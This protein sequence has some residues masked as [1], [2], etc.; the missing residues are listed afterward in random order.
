MVQ[1]LRDKAKNIFTM[2][3]LISYNCRGLH[4]GKCKAKRFVVDNL[5]MDAD[6]LCLQE[7][8]L[9]RQDLKV[10]NGITKS[11]HGIGEASRDKQDG[12]IMGHPPGGVAIFWNIKYEEYISELK[13]DLDWVVGIQVEF[14]NRKFVILNVYMPHQSPENEEEYLCKLGQLTSIIDELETTSISLIGDFNANILSSTSLFVNHLNLF[15]DDNNLILSSKKYLPND[16]FTYVSESWHTVSWLDHCISTNDMHKAVVKMEILYSLASTDH[17]PFAVNLDINCV[18]STLCEKSI[19]KSRIDWSSLKDEDINLYCNYTDLLLNNINICNE[20]LACSNASCSDHNHKRSLINMYDQIVDCLAKASQGLGKNSGSTHYNKPGWNDHVS[21]LYKLSRDAFLVWK[22]SGKPRHGDVFEMKRRANARFKYALRYISNHEEVLRRESLARKLLNKNPKE[23]WKEIK[24]MNNCN[25]SLPTNIEGV[26]GKKN[27]AELWRKHY[28]ELFNSINK[29]NDMSPT[30][31]YSNDMVVYGTEIEYAIGKLDLNKTSGLDG[32]TAEHLKYCSKRINTLLAHCFT[33]LIIHGILPDSMLSIVLVPVIKDKTGQIND[34][35][36]YRPIALASVLSK[37][38]E[39]IILSRLEEFLYTNHNQ[40]GFKKKL[41]TDICIYTLKEILSK[42]ASL[43]ANM[44]LCFLD[45]SKA[46][47]RVNHDKLF[48]KL[49]DRKVPGYLVRILI[50]WYNHQKMTVRWGDETSNS[51]TVS[52]GVRQGGILSPWLFNVY[53]DGL[54]DKL[55]TC[56]VG[57]VIGSVIV[58]H[59]MYADDLVIFSPSA[60]GLTALINI[61][62]AYGDE[63]DILYNQKKSA[64]MIVRTSQYKNVKFP[65]FHLNGVKL[66]EL[67][68]IKYLGHMLS[69]DLSDDM[70]IIRQNRQLYSQGNSLIRKFHMCTKEI[71]IMLF[72]T[73]CS[74]MYTVQLWWNYK[75]GTIRKLYVAYNNIFRLL[76]GIPRFNN[77]VN[78]SAS[79]TFVSNEVSNCASLIRKLVYR[80]ITR[81]DSCNNALTAMLVGGVDCDTFFTSKIRKHWRSLLYLS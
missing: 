67:N 57:C 72:K 42:Y 33:G 44:F 63:N 27:I 79:H 9:W 70:D 69:S 2:M 58:N 18:P 16:S 78:Y 76:L 32:V 6:I 41:G 59:L 74:S 19:H 45:A 75:L 22:D 77:N 23:F 53:M 47:D 62:T 20:T 5:F 29:N 49:L 10:L 11:F 4:V 36:N 61:C 56:K 80:F 52:N 35:C 51:F 34:T 40:F 38:F 37:V 24:I 30:V 12:L 39:Y 64:V 73:Y 43:N 60:K 25:M 21:D 15:C 28:F 65:P 55:N 50:F 17:I 31:T 7:T 48:S 8:W 1:I 66:S 68:H 13:F 54:S 26:T 3:R 81:L 46:F 71:K 14:E